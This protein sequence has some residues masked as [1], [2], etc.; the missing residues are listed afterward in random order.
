MLGHLFAF[1]F[2][3]LWNGSLA[4]ALL[5]RSC[6]EMHDQENESCSTEHEEFETCPR[7]LISH[8]IY[9]VFVLFIKSVW[10][11]RVSFSPIV[12][13]NPH[14]FQIS[15]MLI[16][17]SVNPL[18]SFSLSL[19]LSSYSLLHFHLLPF[20]INAPTILQAASLNK[21]DWTNMIF[22]LGIPHNRGNVAKLF[23]T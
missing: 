2:F 17:H 8:L 4:L 13:S 1:L 20:D 12:I 22:H 5:T 23:T 16:S 3:S 11:N 9:V 6:G 19:S 7:L 10:N 14:H 21:L 15:P 18:L